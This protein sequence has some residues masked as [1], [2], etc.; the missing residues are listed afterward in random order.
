[1]K[2]EVQARYTFQSEEP[3]HARRER[4][5]DVSD[6]I[7]FPG[8]FPCFE[9]AVARHQTRQQPHPLQFVDDKIILR[10]GGEKNLGGSWKYDRRRGDGRDPSQN[11]Q[12]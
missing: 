12:N 5:F 9:S 1:M 7:G 11:R 3:Y 4:I 10:F 2:P 8:H 6:F